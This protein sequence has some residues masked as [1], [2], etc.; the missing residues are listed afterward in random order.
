VTSAQLALAWIR[1]HSG[2]GICG[3][4]IPI[5]GAT[6]VGR[7]NENCKAVDISAEEKAELDK[8]IKS[9]DV[10]GHRQIPG[11]ESNIWT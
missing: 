9:F 8:I 2:T 3:T 1:A 5:P 11:L 4:I 10:A 7:V 6:V